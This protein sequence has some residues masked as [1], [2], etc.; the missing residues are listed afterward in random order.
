MNLVACSLGLF[1]GPQHFLRARAHICAKRL[2]SR[3]HQAWRTAR[4]RQGRYSLFRHAFTLPFFIPLS[5]RYIFHA[6]S[7]A[8]HRARALRS[9]GGGVRAGG[10]DILFALTTPLYLYHANNACAS[11][12][13]GDA[14]YFIV[15]RFRF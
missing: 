13:S 7:R 10:A 12:E 14:L 6:G 15:V 1:F 3:A 8:V 5:S 9:S 11:K 2:V 4:L